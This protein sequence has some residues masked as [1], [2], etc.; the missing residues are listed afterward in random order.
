MEPSPRIVWITGA[1]SGI[2]RALAEAFVRNGDTVIATARQESRLAEL[3]AAVIDAKGQCLAWQCDML[4]GAQVRMLASRIVN[5]FRRIDILINNAGVTYF[6]DFLSTSSEEFNEVVDT[7][8]KGVFHTTQAV[9]P[10]MVERGGG[11]ILNVIS[12][13]AKAT[14]TQS[15]AYS[16]SKAGV[17]ALM[18]VLRAE[19][20]DKGIK[21]M[22]VFPGAVLTPIWHPRHREK[23]ADRMMKPD[24]LADF[25]YT[26]TRQPQSMMIED[27]IVR[28]QAGDLKV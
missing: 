20:R 28:P 6:N 10:S 19:V 25:I 2:G 12:Y 26:L 18:D 15:A 23:Y 16:A 13:A 5:D 14:Y 21:V 27:I 3:Q 24:E 4:E 8:L 7:N 22:N 9:V 11:I 1:S 17:E